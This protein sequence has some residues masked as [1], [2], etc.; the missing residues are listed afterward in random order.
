MGIRQNSKSNTWY[1]LVIYL[2]SWKTKAC[3]HCFVLYTMLDIMHLYYFL[4]LTSETNWKW[5]WVGG[6]FKCLLHLCQN[7]YNLSPGSDAYGWT[8]QKFAWKPLIDFRS[9][10]L[11]IDWLFEGLWPFYHITRHLQCRDMYRLYCAII[12]WWN[13][14]KIGSSV[15]WI[16]FV[17]R[18]TPCCLW[19]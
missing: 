14:C 3:L 7:G 10:D 9:I 16:C 11:M 13:G 17:V 18:R 6:A 15:N 1:C 4:I 5:G 19:L 2:S 8:S 12:L